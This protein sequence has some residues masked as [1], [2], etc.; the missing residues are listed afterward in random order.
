MPNNTFL[1]PDIIANEALMVLKNNLIMAGLVHRDHQS[2]FVKVGDTVTIRKPAEFVAKNFTGTVDPQDI[3]EAGVPVKMDRFRD[4]TVQVGSKEM[5]LDIK[6]FSSQVIT[7]AMQAIA[8]AIDADVLATAVQGASK[9]VD[10]SDDKADKPIRDIARVGTLLDISA[11]PIQNRRLVLNPLHKENYAMDDNMS[12]VSYAGDSRALRDAELGKI[13]TMDTYMSQNAPYPYG[14]L[15]DKVGTAKAYKVSGKAGEAEVALSSLNT[16]AATVKVGDCFIVEGYV[17]RIAEDK[18]GAS[19]V[20]E[21]VKIDQPLHADLTNVDAAVVTAP[22]SVGFHRNGIALVSRALELP[23]GNKNAHVASADGLA[24]RVVFD[25]DSTHKVD[26]CSFD[27]I[28]G[29]KVLNDK[30]IVKIS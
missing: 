18:T 8:Q 21:S 25:Y 14:Y 19:S 22:T 3:T 10:A 29:T 11:V 5:T 24:V 17:Y 4:V 30:M 9:N 1:T 20:I 15:D 26:R 27:I 2:E 7:P 16:A 23:M 13:Y 28:Y 6:S 12:K